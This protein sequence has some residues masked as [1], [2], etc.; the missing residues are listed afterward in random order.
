MLVDPADL[1]RRFG[2]PPGM[3]PAEIAARLAGF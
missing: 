1:R 2:Y 3:A